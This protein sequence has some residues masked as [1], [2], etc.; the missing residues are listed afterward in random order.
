MNQ[1]PVIYIGNFGPPHS[2]ENHV[3]RALT[4]SERVY[5]VASTQEDNQTAWDAL[6][7]DNGYMLERLGDGR[8]GIVLWTKTGTLARDHDTQLRM[9]E[10]VRAAGWITVGFHLDR[11]WG[12]DREEQLTTEPFFRQDLVVTADGHP[13]NPW[14]ELGINHLWLPPA[15]SLA[16]TVPAEPHRLFR[17]DVAF[18]GSWMT[19]RYHKE[20]AMRAE[21]IEQLRIR[22]R[23]RVAFWP[24]PHR[25]NPG[26]SVRGRQLRQLYAS[27]KVAV[28]DSCLVPDAD[29]RPYRRYWSDRVPET[30]GRGCHLVHPAVDGLEAAFPGWDTPALHTHVLGDWGEMNMRIDMALALDADERTAAAETTRLFVQEHHTYERRVDQLLDHIEEEE[31]SPCSS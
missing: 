13:H 20:W 2:T 26:P 17:A 24:Q 29:G 6:G 7:G 16:E 19:G 22:W 4:A 1:T 18:V 10:A 28:G 23:G 9:I 14:A 11:W 21:L 27:T 25:G 3:L 8:P 15:V 31:L 12:L 30:L 5:R